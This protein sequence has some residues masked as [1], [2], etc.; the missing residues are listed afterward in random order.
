MLRR[1]L[2]DQVVLEA[3]DHRILNFKRTDDD[4]FPEDGQ[5]HQAGRFEARRLIEV[6][7]SEDDEGF[8]TAVNVMWQQ[9]GTAKDREHAAEPVETSI[10]KS[11]HDKESGAKTP[12]SQ[13]SSRP[14][15]T[16][17]RP[18]AAANPPQPAGAAAAPPAPPTIPIQPISTRPRRT[19]SS[20]CKSI[21]TIRARRC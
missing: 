7:S 14:S 3:D 1:I 20:P 4:P 2:K 13:R 21:R 16:P 5:R 17:R 6:E 15:A 8:L 12:K 18:S 19:K 11:S 10:A 9:D